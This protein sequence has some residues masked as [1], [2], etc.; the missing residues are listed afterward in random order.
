MEKTGLDIKLYNKCLIHC[1]FKTDIVTGEDLVV[2][3]EFTFL[4]NKHL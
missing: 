2:N 4:G 3:E 1:D